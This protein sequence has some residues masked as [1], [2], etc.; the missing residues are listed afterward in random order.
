[1]IHRLTTMQE[2]GAHGREILEG[3]HEEFVPEGRRE[4]NRGFTSLFI[5]SPWNGMAQAGAAQML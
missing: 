2:N 4:L 5:P 1:M 3:A